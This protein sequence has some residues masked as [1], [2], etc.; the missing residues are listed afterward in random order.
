MRYL[1]EHIAA[2]KDKAYALVIITY[3]LHVCDSNRKDD[4]FNLLESLAIYNGLSFQ[5]LTLV[6]Y[7][8]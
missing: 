1:Y 5:I 2:S 8:T 7:A 3:A 6:H 4:A